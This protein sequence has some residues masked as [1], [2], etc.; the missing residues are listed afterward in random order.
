MYGSMIWYV[1]PIQVGMSWEGHLSGFLVGL[2]FAMIYKHKGIQ[3]PDP[4]FEETAFDLLFDEN[5]NYVPPRSDQE[6]HDD[7]KTPLSD[8]GE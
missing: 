4:Y 5:G 6:V 2:V 8:P 3:K 7:V 1:L